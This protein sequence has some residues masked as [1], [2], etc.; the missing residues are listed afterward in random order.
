MVSMGRK[1]QDGNPKEM[2]E[3]YGV[4]LWKETRKDL[5]LLTSRVYFSVGNGWSASF[6]KDMWHGNESLDTSF[7]SLFAIVASKEA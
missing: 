2:R 6:W 5:G 3:N 4:G 7:P 1:I